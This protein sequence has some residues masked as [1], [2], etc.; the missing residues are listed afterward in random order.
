MIPFQIILAFSVCVVCLFI[1]LVWALWAAVR[2]NKKANN[3]CG[4]PECRVS[5]GICGNLTFG[6]GPLDQHGYWEFPCYLCEAKYLR[7]HGSTYV[8]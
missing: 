6:W 3:G 7:E 5:T 8:G 2:W 1:V 4:D